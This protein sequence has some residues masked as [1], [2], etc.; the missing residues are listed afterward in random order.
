MC[1]SAEYT[2]D[3]IIKNNLIL[4]RVDVVNGYKYIITK[5]VETENI[6]GFVSDYRVVWN[7]EE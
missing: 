5:Q 2:V 4:R 3:I 7:T 6:F 1:T